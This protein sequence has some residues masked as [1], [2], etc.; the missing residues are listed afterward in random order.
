MREVALLFPFQFDVLSFLFMPN[1]SSWNSRAGWTSSAESRHPCSVLD[2]RG[3]LSVFYR[4][5]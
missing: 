1:C 5:V 2:L 3:K 4:R